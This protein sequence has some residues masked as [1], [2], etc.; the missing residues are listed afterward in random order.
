[1]HTGKGEV[2]HIVPF[3][4]NENADKFETTRTAV[5]WSALLFPESVVTQLLDICA[6]DVGCSDKRWNMVYLNRQ[7]HFWW[8]RGYL[9]LKFHGWVK[10][11][12]NDTSE[13]PEVIVKVQFHWLDRRTRNASDEIL[14]TGDASSMRAMAERQMAFEQDGS[15]SHQRGEEGGIIS[16]FRVDMCTPIVSGHIAEVKMPEQDAQ[17]FKALLELQW[18]IIRIAAMSG[19][20]ENPELLPEPE[21]SSDW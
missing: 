20:A 12:D 21:S 15:P 19:A 17:K 13:N 11:S 2:A 8:S 10:A 1:M 9:G 4:W 6:T 16:A 14:I 3:T 7:L 5:S 18:S